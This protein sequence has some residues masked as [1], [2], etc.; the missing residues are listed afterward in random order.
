MMWHVADPERTPRLELA[1]GRVV[2]VVA[3]TDACE[4]PGRY[5]VRDA[6]GRVFVVS[7]DAVVGECG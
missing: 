3:F 4:I 5:R 2:D 6:A 1:D 7:A